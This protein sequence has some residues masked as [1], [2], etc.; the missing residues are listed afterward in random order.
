MQ[1]T[2]AAFDR[3]RAVVACPSLRRERIDTCHSHFAFR[4]TISSPATAG[5]EVGEVERK[6]AQGRKETNRRNKPSEV[7]AGEEGI[8][9][10]KKKRERRTILANEP[11]PIPR[12]FVLSRRHLGRRERKEHRVGASDKRG[13]VASVIFSRKS[14]YIV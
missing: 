8:K 10:K 6:N 7:E 9:K 12:V 3:R 11:L 1:T 14:G 5:R 4:A 2:A 13:G